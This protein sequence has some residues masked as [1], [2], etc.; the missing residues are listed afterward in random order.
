MMDC[1]TNVDPVS[2]VAIL[3]LTGDVDAFAVGRVRAAFDAMPRARGTVI[4]LEG[5]SF[6]DSAG[7][8]VLVGGL[9]RLREHGHTVAICCSTGRVRRV[10]HM[11]GLERITTL[12]DDVETAITAVTAGDNGR[13]TV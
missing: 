10:L 4:D 6:L 9:R 5:V 3:R 1:A 12:Y 8:G 11:I 7:I 13:A 2:G